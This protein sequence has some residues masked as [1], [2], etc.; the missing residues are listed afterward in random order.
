MHVMNDAIVL[1]IRDSGTDKR[2]CRNGGVLDFR[3]LMTNCSLVV[4]AVDSR[5]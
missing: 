2:D 5:H 4:S 3:R 1:L